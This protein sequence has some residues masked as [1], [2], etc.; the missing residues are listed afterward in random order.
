MK[1]YQIH[2]LEAERAY[3]LPV[4]QR[5]IVIAELVIFEP[6]VGELHVMVPSYEE[7]LAA[8]FQ[9]N[10]DPEFISGEAAL[11]LAQQGLAAEEVT[12]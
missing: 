4:P 7:P 12:V 10:Y 1:R 5:E 8:I 11:S 9:G 3:S 2:P 6:G